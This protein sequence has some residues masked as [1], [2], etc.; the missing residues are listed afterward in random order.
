MITEKDVLHEWVNCNY[1]SDNDSSITTYRLPEELLKPI[2]EYANEF[3]ENPKII[4]QTEKK[5]F[6]QLS[7]NDR[8][9]FSIYSAIER[10]LSSYSHDLDRVADSAYDNMDIILGKRR[11]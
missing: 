9:A 10:Y 2:I 8:K 11:D 6:L 5:T 7:E 3:F 4:D 1:D